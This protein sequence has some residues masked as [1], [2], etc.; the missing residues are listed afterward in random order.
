VTLEPHEMARARKAAEEI[1]AELLVEPA[2]AVPAPART[3]HG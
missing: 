2:I 1:V 3:R